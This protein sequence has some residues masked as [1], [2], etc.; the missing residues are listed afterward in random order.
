MT[1]ATRNFDK[2]YKYL[3][4]LAKKE[5]DTPMIDAAPLL[6]KKFGI[7]RGTAMYILKQWMIRSTGKQRD[8]Y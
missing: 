3:D 5:S 6:V 7:D 8:R 4:K 2:E 1:S